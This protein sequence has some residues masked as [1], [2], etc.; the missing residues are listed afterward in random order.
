M[1]ES[2]SWKDWLENAPMSEE[3][4]ERLSEDDNQ[5][6]IT[7]KKVRSMAPEARLDLHGMIKEVAEKEVTSF[8][9]TAQKDN[10]LKVIII[11][12]KG[13]H[14]PGGVDVLEEVVKRVISNTRC[15]RETYTPK[16]KDG[17]SGALMVILKNSKIH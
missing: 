12:G 8:F 6:Y 15:V 3:E 17:G 2:I 16:E 14:S 9:K 10:L 11:F 1:N 4:A 5:S 7:I 13:Y